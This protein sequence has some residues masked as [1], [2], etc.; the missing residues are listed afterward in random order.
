MSY[1]I[2]SF[3]HKSYSIGDLI[4]SCSPLVHV[5]DEQYRRVRCHCCLSLNDQ[6]KKCSKCH[7]MYYC[8]RQCQQKDWIY[9]KHECQLFRRFGRE[10]TATESYQLEDDSKPYERLLMRLWLLLRSNES[11]A[12]EPHQLH[13]EKQLSLNQIESY[14][15]NMKRSPSKLVLFDYLCKRFEKFGLSFDKEL[16][17]ELFCKI[18]RYC[19]QTESSALD[20]C[21]YYVLKNP[22]K[23]LFDGITFGEFNSFG[24]YIPITVFSHSC[25]PNASQV[26][27]GSQ[28]QLRAIKPIHVNEQITISYLK[29]AAFMPKTDRQN[30]LKKYYVNCNCIKC[31]PNFDN[32][33]DYERLQY[34]M[35]E[36]FTYKLSDSP[37]LSHINRLI[38]IDQ[39]CIELLKKFYSEF[40]P[41][42]MQI[43]LHLFQSRH[44][45]NYM[46][47]PNNKENLDQLSDLIVKCIQISHGIDH[48]LY[49]TFKEVVRRAKLE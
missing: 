18:K 12:S 45:H 33:F 27:N 29:N 25:T 8:D 21:S 43:Y 11:I 17:F 3:A 31:E 7:Q 28:I 44:I 2:N 19:I 47:K 4:V 41:N 39:E 24:L 15:T 48:P 22:I 5:I 30:E 9:H 14:S 49:Q 23:N 1:A 6:L 34:L 16:L 38:E 42:L 10:I 40:N 20:Q 37:K 36:R 46:F 26:F 35:F 13:N 32:S